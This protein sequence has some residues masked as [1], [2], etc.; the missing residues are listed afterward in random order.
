MLIHGIQ[1]LEA[2]IYRLSYSLTQTKNKSVLDFGFWI[3]DHHMCLE[4]N[5]FYLYL[6]FSVTTFFYYTKQL[7]FA[8]SLIYILLIPDY[9]IFFKNNVIKVVFFFSTSEIPPYLLK[10][11]E[12]HYFF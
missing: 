4:T 6:I 8:T 1:S 3:L 5:Y 2:C 12:T 11:I 10:S 9:S 7:G